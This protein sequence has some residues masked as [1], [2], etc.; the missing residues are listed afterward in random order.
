MGEMV[1][2][3]PTEGTDVTPSRRG[4]Q[5]AAAKGSEAASELKSEAK[6][7]VS[8]VAGQAKDLVSHR[9]T[10]S[11]GK[12]AQDIH[13]VARALR[14]TGRD[15]GP[16]VA[17]PYVEK[18]AD[19]LDRLSRFLRDANPTEVARDVERFAR[20]EPLL[21]LG[22]AFAVGLLAARF[23]KSSSHHEGAA[24]WSRDDNGD[25]RFARGPA[26][27]GPDFDREGQYGRGS[28]Y[29]RQSQSP[30]A[31]EDQAESPS[32]GYGASGSFLQRGLQEKW[33]KSQGQQTPSQ[34]APGYEGRSYSNTEG[35]AAQPGQGTTGTSFPPTP[36]RPERT[37]P[38]PGE[39]KAPATRPGGST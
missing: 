17:A 27:R 20:R 13:E 8:Q 36:A 11:A 21:F 32:Q 3:F 34:G 18:A 29:A 30:P 2:S 12:S 6:E 35:A 16:N 14:D 25:S 24:E 39:V 4:A 15:L 33:S 19:Q 7:V 9:V 26:Y 22:G 37:P 38:I 1:K 5:G 10:E 31:R 28:Q 23:L